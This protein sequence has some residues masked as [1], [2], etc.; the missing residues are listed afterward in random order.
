LYTSPLFATL[1]VHILTSAYGPKCDKWR[2]PDPPLEPP[3]P[4]WQWL[5]KELHQEGDWADA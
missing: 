5:E 1:K 3:F 2:E 4:E